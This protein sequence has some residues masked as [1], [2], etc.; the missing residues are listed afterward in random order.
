MV[1]SDYLFLQGLLNTGWARYSLSVFY[2]YAFGISLKLFLCTPFLLPHDPCLRIFFIS[3][4]PFSSLS[5]LI[6]VRG[7]RYHWPHA[8]CTFAGKRKRNRTDWPGLPH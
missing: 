6:I 5:T 4:V 3:A 1:K 2:L 8:A 7:R